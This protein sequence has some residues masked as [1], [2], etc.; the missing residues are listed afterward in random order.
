MSTSD[1][2]IKYFLESP[3]EFISG[4]KISNRLGVSRT[5]VWKN[6]RLLRNEGYKIEVSKGRGYRLR[7]LT[8]LPI[9]REIRRGLLTK[10]LGKRVLF[11]DA[12]DSTNNLAKEVARKKAEEGVVIIST[13]QTKGR[14]RLNRKWESPKG[15]LF[16]SIILNP[17]IHPSALTSLTLLAGLSTVKAIKSLYDLDVKLKWPNDLL[18]DDMKLGGILC[19]M[20]GEV[21]KVNFVVVGIGIDVNCDVDVDI[22]TTSI[23]MAIGRSTSIIKLV[24]AVLWEFENLYFEFLSDP[25]LFIGEYKKRSHTLGKKAKIVLPKESVSGEAVDIERDGALLLKLSDGSYEKFFSGDCIH[26]S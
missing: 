12:V 10:R 2:I 7:K 25:S 21:D 20:E 6:I 18:F 8:D 5:W 13:E 16:M 23:K 15:G 11:H 19:E 22:P 17:S 24:Q 9:E 1:R 4:E 26:L 3:N 14:G